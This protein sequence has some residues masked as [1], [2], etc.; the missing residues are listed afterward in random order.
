MEE[1]ISPGRSWFEDTRQMEHV[2]E[3]CMEGDTVVTES[4]ERIVLVRVLGY[5]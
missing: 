3:T 5:R 1:P 2:Q 4:D